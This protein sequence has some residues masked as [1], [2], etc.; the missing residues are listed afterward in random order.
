[1]IKCLIVDNDAT[2]LQTLASYVEKV[3]FLMLAGS[4]QSV[5]EARTVIE[6]EHVDAV[7]VETGL[8]D[9]NALD[10]VR[11]LSSAPIVVLMSADAA[12]AVDGY[13]VSA[14]YYLLKPLDY[15]EFLEATEHVKRRY[16]V[17][18]RAA[19]ANTQTAGYDDSIFLKSDHRMVKVHMSDIK[20]IEGMSEYLKVHIE[21]Q[22]P[23][24][25][26]LSMKRIEESLPASFMRVHR[27]YIVNLKRIQEVSKSRIILDEATELPVGDN[28]REQ[29]LQFLNKRVLGK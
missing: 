27:S 11:S 18:H 10:L 8:P 25:M 3:P 12:C 7:F 23:I 13:K 9:G 21:N 15:N 24:V 6:N 22:R 19:T 29:F 17:L 14:A 1:M 28:Y 4:C 20:Y 5:A 16:Y 26:L 2:A